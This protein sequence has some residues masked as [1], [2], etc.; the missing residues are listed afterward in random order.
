MHFPPGRGWRTGGFSSDRSVKLQSNAVRVSA[1]S[2][3]VTRKQVDSPV[4]T[5][6]DCV[7]VNDGGVLQRNSQAQ[8]GPPLWGGGASIEDWDI[9]VV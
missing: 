3:A 2:V 6:S 4:S 9:C 7:A 1:V 8:S 5:V